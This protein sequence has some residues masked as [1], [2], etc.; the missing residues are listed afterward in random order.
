MPSGGWWRSQRGL[1]DA[2]AQVTSDDL[3]GSV[4][5]DLQLL[6]E[7]EPQELTLPLQNQRLFKKLRDTR[8]V[9]RVQKLTEE[10][11]KQV[12]GRREEERRTTDGGCV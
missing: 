4:Q 11:A 6:P 12:R 9:L 5:V 2:C 1:T 8:L 3:V 10:E 7:G